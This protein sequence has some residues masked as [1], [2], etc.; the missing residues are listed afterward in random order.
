M[1]KLSALAFLATILLM[2][3]QTVR[4][5]DPAKI[6]LLGTF[7]FANPG[8]DT[9]KTS[10]LDV[11][12]ADSQQYL[13]AFSQK[14]A[15][16]FAPTDVLLECA[17]GFQGKLN[18]QYQQYLKGEFSLPVNEIYQLGFRVAKAAGGS[19]VRCFDEHEIQWNADQLF[20]QMPA[21]APVIQAAFETLIAE[22]TAQSNEM[23]QTLSLAGVLRVMNSEQQYRLNQSI[24]LLSNEVGAGD[25]FVGADAA[26]S[27]WHRNF[28]MYAN[29]QQAASPG[30]RVLVI[31]GQGHIAVIKDFLASDTQRIAV[32]VDSFL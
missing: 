13:Q 27:W 12:S 10:V 17:V 20:E 9:V 25:N 22:V 29:I 2:S 1:K 16:D 28:R 3:A 7:H 24:Y 23:H 26:A 6:M 18:E 31:A 4:A 11:S 5:G 21:K 8:L 15:K 32:F 14:I 30:K 19:A